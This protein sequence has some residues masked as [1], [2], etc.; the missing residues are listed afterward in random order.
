MRL[1]ILRHGIAEERGPGGDDAKRALTKE[2]VDELRQVM[3]A[4]RHAKV[5]PELII[6]SPYV[7]AVQTAKV[8]AQVLGH[9]QPLVES[10]A[11]VPSSTPQQVW[12]EVRIHK[13]APE[14]MIVGHDPLFSHIIG[15]LLGAPSAQVDMKKGALAR[16]DF[17]SFGVQPRGTLKW[18]IHP[19]LVV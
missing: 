17:E 3:R 2:G 18:L 9:M 15:H 5:N 10:E 4:A 12:E 1:Y 6:T 8:A 14:L 13:A 7:R 19:K 16:I 11:L